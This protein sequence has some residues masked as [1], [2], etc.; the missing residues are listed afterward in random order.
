[1]KQNVPRVGDT[2]LG[3]QVCKHQHLLASP[4]R[5]SNSCSSFTAIESSVASPS[6][7]AG[8]GGGGGLIGGGSEEG[9]GGAG[10][11]VLKQEGDVEAWRTLREVKNPIYRWVTVNRGSNIFTQ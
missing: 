6:G 1:M 4:T 10:T 9:G 5:S 8:G 2:I 7:G 11:S 3:G